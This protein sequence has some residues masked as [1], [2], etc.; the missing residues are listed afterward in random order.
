MK[1]IALLTL[2]LALVI[3]A[4][5]CSGGVTYK[6]D[7]KTDDIASAVQNK[8]SNASVLVSAD[9]LYLSSFNSSY[10]SLISDWTIMYSSTGMLFDEFGIFKVENTADTD[11]IVTMINEFIQLRIDGD[12]GYVPDEL[13]KIKNAKTKVCGKYVMY[14]F[15]SEGDASAA[16]S[17][18]E[19]SLTK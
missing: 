6:T 3:C 13:P 8:L 15:L 16:F 11:S 17:A 2:V 10:T 4:V 18:F 9:E 7:V 5:S 1:K 12:M 19:D 14:A